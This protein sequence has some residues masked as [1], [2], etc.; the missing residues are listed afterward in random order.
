MRT[1]IA[2]ACVAATITERIELL[3]IADAQSRLRLDP[4]AQP[5]LE[6][7]VRKRIEG[8]ERQ[9]SARLAFGAIASDQ[10]CGL[11]VL[12]GHDRGGQSDF[13]GREVRVGHGETVAAERGRCLRTVSRRRTG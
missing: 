12:D 3:D 1:G 9:A 2:R 11:L 4:G 13:N 7:A 8:S 5:A 10:D 6:G